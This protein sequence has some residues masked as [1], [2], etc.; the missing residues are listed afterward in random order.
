[1]LADAGILGRR[2]HGTKVHYRIVDEG[3]FALCEQV[4][5]AVGEQLHALGELLAGAGR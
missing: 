3:V 5:G 2:K 1:V 4:C